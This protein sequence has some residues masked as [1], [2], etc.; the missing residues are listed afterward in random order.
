MPTLN[1]RLVK[2]EQ[3]NTTITPLVII[4]QDDDGLTPEQ[5]AQVD[6]ADATQSPVL[7]I[8]INNTENLCYE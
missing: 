3:R 6:E 4:Y 7:L 8:R 2:L 1:Q 5:Q